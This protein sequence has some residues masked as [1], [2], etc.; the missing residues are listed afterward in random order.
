MS[1]L[2]SILSNRVL[3]RPL[4]PKAIA[5]YNPGIKHYADGGILN[6][7]HLSR[8]DLV[9]DANGY[10][11]SGSLYDDY[12]PI[13]HI[14]DDITT[15][16]NTNPT[17]LDPIREQRHRIRQPRQIPTGQPMAPGTD[18]NTAHLPYFNSTPSSQPDALDQHYESQAMAMDAN[19]PNLGHPKWYRR[20]AAAAASMVPIANQFAPDIAYGSNTANQL[21]DYERRL[22]GVN[23]AAAL[24]HS[25][26]TNSLGYYAKTSAELDREQRDREMQQHQQEVAGFNQEKQRDVEDKTPIEP[27]PSPSTIPSAQVPLAVPQPPRQFQSPPS[28]GT[29]VPPTSPTGGAPISALG[30]PPIQAN[31]PPVRLAAPSIPPGYQ[32]SSRLATPT[33]PAISGMSPTAATIKQ[34]ESEAAGKAPI[35]IPP[36]LQQHFPDQ[37]TATP[38]AIQAVQHVLDSTKQNED[39]QTAERNQTW[40]VAAVT[41]EK[42][43]P[44]SYR[45]EVIA[46]AKDIIAQNAADKAADRAAAYGV[47]AADR[48]SKRVE[49]SYNRRIGVVD[50]LE[51]PIAASSGNIA[52]AMTAINQGSP[53][54]DSMA[55]PLI[56]KATVSGAGSGFRM[57]QAE[58][59]SVLGGSTKWVA[60][61]RYLNQWS[62]DPK[63]PR[64]PDEQ[65]QQM[66]DILQAISSKV[67]SK[68][69]R[70]L[71][72]RTDLTDS[73]DPKE[74]K[75]IVDG[76]MKDI[77]DIDA[78][79]TGTPSIPNVKTQ[80]EYNKLPTGTIYMEDGK[81]YRKP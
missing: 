41:G 59:N 43:R 14:D 20:L 60:L 61:E 53:L 19:P 38:S 81:Q 25:A 26:N 54:A 68:T 24:E 2:T 78:G 58:M 62:L 15:D 31:I 28:M 33:R 23:Q 73:E 51:A 11:G 65:R 72:A 9:S 34:Q 46:Q 7:I 39:K 50:K 80:D 10:T 77:N 22:P 3:G 12:E 52:E 13:G 17:D 8:P 66:R 57:T 45:P 35:T 4:D 74:H 48:S 75:Q 6:G 32:P 30:A 44:G 47:G 69:Q 27:A 5:R 37:T 79:P 29:T 40:A 55:V 21:R 67:Q 64:I 71:K 42:A 1:N 16:P 56:L 18:P 49:D 76:L 70:I 36:E 63:H